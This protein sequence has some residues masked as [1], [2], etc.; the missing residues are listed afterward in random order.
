[1][2]KRIYVDFS[3]DPLVFLSPSD[4]L[5]KKFLTA[6]NSQQRKLSQKSLKHLLFSL[7]FHRKMGKVCELF[8][9]KLVNK[10]GKVGLIPSELLYEKRR[11][12]RDSTRNSM[13]RTSKNMVQVILL[14]LLLF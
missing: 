4:F 5:V 3:G 14:Y 1:M 13:R 10:Q 7:K 6:P 2:L 8:N 12:L 11:A 9:F